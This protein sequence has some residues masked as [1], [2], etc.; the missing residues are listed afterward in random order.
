MQLEGSE[1]AHTQNKSIDNWTNKKIYAQT[2]I[3][4]DQLKKLKPEIT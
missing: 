2:S 3:K 4:I 1:R